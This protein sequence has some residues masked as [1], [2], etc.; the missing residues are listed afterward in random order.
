MFVVVVVVCL[1]LFVWVF[2]SFYWKSIA[3]NLHK[4]IILLA[5]I[6]HFSTWKEKKRNFR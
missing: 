5:Q 2:F 1:G 3:T 4:T 6:S